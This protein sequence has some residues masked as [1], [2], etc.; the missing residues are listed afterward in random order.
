MSDNK[1][2]FELIASDKN[3]QAEL[4]KASIEALKELLISNGLEEE[5]HKA[6]EGAMTRVAAAHGLNFSRMKELSDE[7]MKT[8]S[9]GAPCRIMMEAA[10]LS[11]LSGLFEHTMGNFFH[12]I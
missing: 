7:E 3:A 11:G 1:K 10:L 12:V 2:F 4:E 6:L 9:G 5:A 8:A